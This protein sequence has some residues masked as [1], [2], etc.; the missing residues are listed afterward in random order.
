MC[1]GD[2]IDIGDSE[3]PLF[4]GF[5][6]LLLEDSVNH[7]PFIFIK[8]KTLFRSSIYGER[9][10]RQTDRQTDRQADRQAG[11]NKNIKI[12]CLWFVFM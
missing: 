3:L 9:V 5:L 11:N 8:I 4:G 2:I 12:D 1:S 10:D 7:L 6:S